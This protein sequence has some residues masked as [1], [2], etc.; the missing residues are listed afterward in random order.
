MTSPIRRGRTSRMVNE[1][2]FDGG[3]INEHHRDVVLDRI[4]TPA[5]VALESGSLIDQMDRF[6]ACGADQNLEQRRIDGHPVN[7][8]QNRRR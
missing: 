5:V 7:I 6:L 2:G 3:L 4:H 1:S 8:C